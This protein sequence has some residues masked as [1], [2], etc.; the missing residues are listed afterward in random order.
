MGLFNFLKGKDNLKEI[1]VSEETDFVDLQF[2]ITNYSQDE[3]KNH[4]LEIKGLY[5]NDI[6]GLEV[7]LRPDLELGIVN[8]E[9]DSSKFYKEGV[10]FYSIGEIS[11]NFISALTDL[12][13]FD[14]ENLKMNDRIES[15]TFIL[16]GN[17]YKIKTDFIKTKIFFDDADESGLY[18]EL[19]A[20]INLKNKTFELREKDSE[21]RENIIKSLSK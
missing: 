17:P 18:S 14:I 8:D 16:S 10:N 11:D 3:F 6:V 12:Y 2:T 9:V 19:Y 4:I 13:G 7:A 21:Y 5:K 1:N 15:T 20:N